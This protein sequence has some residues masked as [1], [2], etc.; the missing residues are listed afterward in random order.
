MLVDV[1]LIA[2]V[3][4]TM[5]AA[6]M[7]LTVSQIV[8]PLRGGFLPIKALLASFVLVPALALAI[9]AVLPLSDGFGTGLILM[10]T[11]AGASFLPLLVQVA[12]ANV[13]ASVGVLVLLMGTTVLYLPLVLPFLLPGVGGRPARYRPAARAAD[14][15]SPGDRSVREPALSPGCCPPATDRFKDRQPRVG[16]RPDRGFSLSTG[17]LCSGPSAMAPLPPRSF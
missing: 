14:V 7:R 2:F 12:R 6:G 9:R 15:A 3:V 17:E 13:A 16:D 4:G 10:S 8:G 5:A 1:G 11:A